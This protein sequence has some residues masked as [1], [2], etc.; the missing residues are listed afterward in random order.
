MLSRLL[1]LSLLI[2]ASVAP[3]AAQ[4]SP[5]KSPFPSWSQDLLTPP[6]DFHLRLPSLSKNAQIDTSLLARKFPA[7]A[8][9][10]APCF[11][12]R[13]YRFTRDHAKSDSTTFTDYSTCE[14]ST[15][16]HLKDAVTPPSR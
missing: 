5:D 4:S 10:T 11:R 1:I 6:P 12:I 7:L 9:N 3:A 8:Q 2:P 13:S 14:S 16:F 15:Q